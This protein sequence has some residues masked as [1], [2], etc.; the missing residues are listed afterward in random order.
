MAQSEFCSVGR[1]VQILYDSLHWVAVAGADDDVL[2]GATG[3]LAASEP[4]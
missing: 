4:R 3:Q 2:A 1:A